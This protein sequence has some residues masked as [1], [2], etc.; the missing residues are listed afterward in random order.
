LHA[1]AVL[2]GGIERGKLTRREAILVGLEVA[3]LPWLY[4]RYIPVALVLFAVMIWVTLRN[5]PAARD[6]RTLLLGSSAASVSFLGLGAYQLAAFGNPLGYFAENQIQFAPQQVIMIFSGLHWDGLHGMFIENPFLWL[7]LLGVIPFVRDNRRGAAVVGMVY[8]AAIL[9]GAMNSAWYG[10]ASLAGRYT[11]VG[12]ALWAFPL[13]STAQYM[14]LSLPGRIVLALA[15][16][17]NVVLQAA[18]ATIWIGN[19]YIL[20][21]HGIGEPIWATSDLYSPLLQ[22]GVPAQYALPSFRDFGQY[23]WHAPNYLALGFSL[24]LVVS[25]AWLGGAQRDRR[26]LAV[27]WCAYGLAAILTLTSYSPRIEPIVITGARLHSMTGELRG[28]SRIAVSGSR[29]YLVFGPYNRV[30]ANYPYAVTL[31]YQSGRKAAAHY[32]LALDYGNAIVSEGPLPPSA[33]NQGKLQMQLFV[34]ARG[35]APHL[36]AFDI[37]YRGRGRLAVERLEIHPIVAGRS[38]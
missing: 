35:P 26:T 10:G 30:L 33:E 2:L 13:A 7:G 18:L 38:D 15:C 34:T 4:K 21:N 19:D 16:F 9:P 31:S 20:Y 1:T 32:H 12:L 22:L 11:W 8:L 14:L 37:F 5:E 28:D 6:T 17:S 25:G 3:V 27:L 23:A 36:F 24:L 29:G